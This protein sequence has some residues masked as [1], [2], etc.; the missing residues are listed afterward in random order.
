MQ[1]K[2]DKNSVDRNEQYGDGTKIYEALHD[3]LKKNSTKNPFVQVG[4]ASLHQKMHP[5]SP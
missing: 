4:E 1:L 2:K 5:P 3:N